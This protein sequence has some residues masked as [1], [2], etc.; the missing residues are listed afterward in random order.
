MPS[1][2]FD[3]PLPDL[4]PERDSRVVRR[5]AEHLES[6]CLS[7]RTIGLLTGTARH[8]AVGVDGFTARLRHGREYVMLY[9]S[10]RRSRA[11]L[12]EVRQFAASTIQFTAHSGQE[13]RC[14]CIGMKISAGSI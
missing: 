1:K 9:S 7:D 6:L 2:R 3:A 13:G 14:V 12:I 11:N 5:Y 8:V 10:K 4:V